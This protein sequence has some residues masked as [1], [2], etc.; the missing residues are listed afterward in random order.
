MRKSLFF[1][2][3]TNNSKLLRKLFLLPKYVTLHTL[4]H[5]DSLPTFSFVIKGSLGKHFT[6]LLVLIV[7]NILSYSLEPPDLASGHALI[8][9]TGCTVEHVVRRILCLSLSLW[10]LHSLVSHYSITH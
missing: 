2:N 4:T 9:R 10:L 8:L 7:F 1:S 3:E 6:I 5:T